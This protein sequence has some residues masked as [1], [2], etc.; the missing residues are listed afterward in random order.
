MNILYELNPPKIIKNQ[1]FDLSRLEQ[2]MQILVERASKLTEFVDGIHLTDSVLGIPHLSSL[3]AAHFIRKRNNSLNLSCSLRVRDRNFISIFQFV[4]EA[5]L[6]KVDSLLILKGDKPL[7]GSIDVNIIPS[8]VLQILREKNYDTEIDLNLSIPCKF[9]DKLSIQK[10][11]D[12]GPKAFVT[13]SIESIEEL[14]TIVNYCKPY[15]IK[16]IACIM[17]PSENN[18]SSAKAIGLDWQQYENNPIDFI[19]MAAKIADKVLITSPNSFKDG[20]ELVRKL[21]I[22]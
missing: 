8:R 16:V 15:K 19:R 4:S 6:N 20:L 21:R 1:Y 17:M 10:K 9:K 5:I 22:D 3:T 14:T 12:S 13:Q 11:I 2:E 7:D 18:V